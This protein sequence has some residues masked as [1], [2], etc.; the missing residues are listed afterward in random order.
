MIKLSWKYLVA[1]PLNTGLNIL[2]LALGLAIIT[3]LILIEDQFENKMTKDAEGVDLVVGA[4]GSPLQLILSSVYHIDY[5]TG[6]IDMNDAKA[7]S[8]NRLVKNIIPLGMG[9]NYQGY[10]IVGTNH[11][12]L[13][14]YDAGFD[15]GEAWR[16]PF[17]VVLGFEVAKKLGLGLGDT[18]V[19]SH[20]IGSSSHEHDEHPYK[21]TGI[22]SEKGNVLDKL[23]LTSIESVWYSHDE[24][25]DHEKF[26]ADVSITGFPE[27][28][29]DREV[30]SLLLQYRNPIAA[31]QLPRFINSKSALQA[32]SPSFEISRLFELLGVGVKLIQGLA[33]AIIIIAG[34]GIFIALFNSLKERKYDLAVMRTLGASS[35]QLFIHIVLE[36]V[37]LTV[38][39]AIVGIAIGHLFLAVLVMQNEQGAISGLSAAVFLQEELWIVGYAVLVGFIASLIPAWT[40]Y[41]TDIAK[42][43]TKS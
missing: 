39:G 38:L 13:E 34:L 5:P 2:L 1:K 31:V 14:L 9:D 8:R 30:T 21:I 19:G 10:R 29:E 22:L 26:E 40:A 3:V 28:E 32:A 43:L 15:S 36:G 25:H 17:D 27:T 33:I 7:L 37:I 12:Y 16:K 20:G 4:K 23:I 41:Q 6:N 24:G 35:A 18:F 11:D 42:Q